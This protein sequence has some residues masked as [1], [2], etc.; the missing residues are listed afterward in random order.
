MT[1][2]SEQSGRNVLRRDRKIFDDDPLS[3]ERAREVVAVV[4]S[5]GYEVLNAGEVEFADHDFEGERPASIAFVH[6]CREVH[7]VLRRVDFEESFAVV[8]EVAQRN[9]LNS[10][11]RCEH[12]DDAADV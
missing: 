3:V 8:R 6:I 5:N 10:E 7:H 12:A 1:G 4:G 11:G 9:S 2:P